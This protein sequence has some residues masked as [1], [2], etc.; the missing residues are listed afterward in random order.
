M[1]K[2]LSIFKDE[3]G[4]TAVEYGLI[5]ALI[6]LAMVGAVTRF[7]DTTIGMWENVANEVTG[8]SGN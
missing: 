2:F 6:F 5:L 8:A 1:R 4:G 7:S 3:R